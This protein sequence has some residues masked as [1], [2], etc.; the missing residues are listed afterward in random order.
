MV[1]RQ[2]RCVDSLEECPKAVAGGDVACVA[3]G[4]E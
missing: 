4:E 2:R 1:L 3:G